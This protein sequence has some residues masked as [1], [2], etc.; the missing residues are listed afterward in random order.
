MST[1]LELKTDG[2]RAVEIHRAGGG[3]LLR[4]VYRPETAPNES[5]RP[6]AHPVCTL[7]GETLTNFRPNDHPWQHALSFTINCLSGQNF[8]GGPSYRADDGYKFRD[9]HGTQQ[10][11][12]WLEKSATRL[13]HSLDWKVNATSEVLLHEERALNFA[14]ISPQAWTLRWTSALANVS[15]RPLSLGQYHSTHGLAGSH[16]SGLQFRGARDLLDEH[17]DDSI[18]I[19]AE[20]G[21]VGEKALHG[22]SA[23]WVEWRGQ[24]DTS[25]R[26]VN[27]RFANNQGPLSWFFR[28]NN[29]LLAMPFQ[30]NRD[31]QLAP[32]ATLA[33]DHTLTFTDAS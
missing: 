12:A 26:R 11:L 18:N 8:W 33:I 23:Q 20:G 4:Y 16:Y 30:Y 24:K 21:L 22:A 19:F 28:R 31:L 27:I 14:I 1:G 10:H 13:E 17:M 2:D 6:Y 25:L 9:D 3:L 32:G 7:S 5:P 29:P 15:K